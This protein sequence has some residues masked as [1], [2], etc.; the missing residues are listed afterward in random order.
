MGYCEALPNPEAVCAVLGG[1]AY[2]QR[3]A[4]PLH[5]YLEGRGKRE[6]RDL[7]QLS[8]S[9]YLFKLNLA[10]SFNFIYEEARA[11]NSFILF[12]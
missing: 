1:Q 12:L 4:S 10:F 5:Q 3:T 9:I 11:T 2:T 6:K 8:L 7:L